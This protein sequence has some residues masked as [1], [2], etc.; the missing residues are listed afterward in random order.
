MNDKQLSISDAIG[1]CVDSARK[2]FS[3][4]DNLLKLPKIQANL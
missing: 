1:V 2:S 3:A 4:Q